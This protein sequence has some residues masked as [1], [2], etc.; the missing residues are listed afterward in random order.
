MI[1]YH[2]H[3]I[4]KENKWIKWITILWF[5][6]STQVSWSW[7]KDAAGLHSFLE[8]LEEAPFP[9]LFQLLEATHTLRFVASSLRL[10]SQEHNVPHH[11]H[12]SF[13]DSSLLQPLPRWSTLGITL[14]LP[15]SPHPHPHAQGQCLH[16]KV[17]WIANLISF[18]TLIPLCHAN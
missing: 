4:W 16:L 14:D 7:S 12:R 2:Q 1:G 10:Q 13:S 6:S 11:H 5:R 8:A 9:C 17:S 3:R 18:A 15:H